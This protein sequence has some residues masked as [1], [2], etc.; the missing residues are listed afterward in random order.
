M[1][2]EDSLDQ[3]G[4]GARHAD[5]EDR[6]RAVEPLD[7]AVE[8]IGR[9]DL[10]DPVDDAEVGRDV[11]TH[12]RALERRALPQARERRRRSPRGP[13]VPSPARSAAGRARRAI[14]RA[15]DRLAQLGDVIV[16]GG[17]RPE[18]RARRC[19]PRTRRGA[20]RSPRRNPARRPRRR[21]GSG[22]RAARLKWN[23]A[24]PWSSSMA[25]E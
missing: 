6:L 19:R 23:S 24:L 12:Q 25:A 20:A 18:L 9:I 11:V 22:A 7:V 15:R 4:A 5:H 10:A 16:R 21:R 13:R 17:L 3:R 14:A 2:A 8:A 1:A